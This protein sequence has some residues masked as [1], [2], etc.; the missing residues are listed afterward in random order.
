[1]AQVSAISVGL[2]LLLLAVVAVT[3][4]VRDSD[5]T[6]ARSAGGPVSVFV[7]SLAY[8]VILAPVIAPSGITAAS[9]LILIV[10][11]AA[12]A[13]IGGL[14]HRFREGLSGQALRVFDS[15]GVI[16]A[17]ALLVG[18]LATIGQFV[19][20]FGDVNRTVVV[21]VV[22]ISIAGYLFT[23]GRESANRT[24]RW[25]LVMA[26]LVPVLLL[27]GGLFLGSPSTITDSLV[28]FTSVP[29]GSVSALVATIIVLS[30]VDPSI[31]RVVATSARPGKAAL[32]GAVIAGAFAFVL[33][34]GLILIFG[35]A[36]VAPTLQAFLLAAAP[37]VGIGVF[38][39]IATLVLASV[40]DTQLAT[41]SELVD[42]LAFVGRREVV[43]FGF[44]IL[45]VVV[46]VLVPS[47]TAILAIAAILAAAV[48]GALMPALDRQ[49]SDFNA[50]P[51]IFGGV[52]AAVVVSL[53][54]G[55]GSVLTFRVA[56]EVAI[57]G[58][59]LIGAAVSFTFAKS[60]RQPVAPA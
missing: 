16:V 60:S 14:A 58:A 6:A 17:F 51:G 21:G 43:T 2:A 41:G 22:G 4:G 19:S 9:M 12:P 24:S 34:I 56:T 27:V 5:K 10:I 45:A 33:S 38:I 25:V 23:R 48:L 57:L 15:L 47:P 40:C 52:A 36:F 3:V 7:A 26:F 30:V 18:I 13:I 11:A 46:A 55:T 53:L 44:A 50:F 1:M 35:G 42:R 59:F 29:L 20:L 8:L 39:F 32:W 31:G 28:P 37:P 54:M 49:T